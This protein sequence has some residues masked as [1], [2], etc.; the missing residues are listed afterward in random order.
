M[1]FML[2]SMVIGFTSCSSDGEE[3][4]I[5]DLPTP[6]YENV[7]GKYVVNNNSSNY[8]SIELTSWKSHSTLTL[9]AT[10]DLPTFLFYMID[11]LKSWC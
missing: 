8:E 2:I 9:L 7:S 4:E 10:Q 3:L 5:S 1:T 6:L 11:P